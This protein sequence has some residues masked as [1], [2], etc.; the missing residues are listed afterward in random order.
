MGRRHAADGRSGLREARRRVGLQ[1][2]N[3]HMGHKQHRVLSEVTYTTLSC[4]YVMWWAGASVCLTWVSQALGSADGLRTRRGAGS[5]S[6]GG[7]RYKHG[8][9]ACY[10]HLCHFV[11]SIRT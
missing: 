6:K 10:V 2:S 3:L 8:Q 1:A 9:C 4:I 5:G 11:L 7:G